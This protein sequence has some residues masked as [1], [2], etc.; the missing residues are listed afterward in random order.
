MLI[1]FLSFLDLRTLGWYVLMGA[2]SCPTICNPMNYSLPGSSVFEIFQ[3]RRL[4]WVAISSSRGSSRSRDRDAS[5]VSPAL[6]GS[7]FTIVP[8]GS[9]LGWYQATKILMLSQDLLSSPRMLGQNVYDFY[10]SFSL[11]LEYKF[12]RTAFS[13][14]MKR[15]SK[16][17]Q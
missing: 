16:A 3:A 15:L 11:C 10:S 13:V 1:L 8:H 4:E 5:P 6:S 2:H 17:V 9:P 14:V 12:P 7:F